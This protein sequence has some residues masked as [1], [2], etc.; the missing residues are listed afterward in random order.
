MTAVATA[1]ENKL[2]NLQKQ[3]RVM[4]KRLDIAKEKKNCDSIPKISTDENDL[5]SEETN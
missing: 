4:A 1:F 2:G 3:F 5:K